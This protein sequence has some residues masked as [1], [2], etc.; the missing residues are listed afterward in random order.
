MHLLFDVGNTTVGIAIAK[1]DTINNTFKINTNTTKTADDYYLDII[2]LIG[3]ID[4]T[5]I[6]ITSVVP[7]VTEVLEEI[8]LKY[9]E[10]TPLILKAGVKTGIKVNT[11]NP[12]EV[13]ADL[14]SDAAAILDYPKPTLIIDLGTAIKYIYVKNNE[15]KGVII[16]PGIEVSI[17]ALVGN[18]AL[19]PQISIDVPKNVLGKN[20]IECMQSGVT[21][22]VAAQIDGLVE[23]I[24]AETN[25]EFDI[26]I[27]GGLSELILPL[28]K[29]PSTHRINLVFEGLLNIYK[30]NLK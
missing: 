2:R 9:F 11:D 7:N 25:E 10:L 14:I 24:S 29:K 28:I 17:K 16:T 21:Y 5:N 27:T 1:D 26:I 3:N 4:I 6:S 30:R 23:R 8:S 19:L 12:R 20:T 18:T 22:G 13:G 15:I